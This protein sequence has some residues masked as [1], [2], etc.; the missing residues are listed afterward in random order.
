MNSDSAEKCQLT[1]RCQ[2]RG[3]DDLSDSAVISS[4]TRKRT[5][6]NLQRGRR[7][8]RATEKALKLLYREADQ[9][10]YC[11]KKKAG[12]R[13]FFLNPDIQIYRGCRTNLAFFLGLLMPAA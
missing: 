4:G 1:G 7:C 9:A 8:I 2:K 3:F 5:L 11:A 10:L 12:I 13:L 6:Y